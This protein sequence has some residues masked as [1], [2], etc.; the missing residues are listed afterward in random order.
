ML[1]QTGGHGDEWMP[2]GEHVRW[3]GPPYPGSPDTI[4]DGPEAMRRKVR[5][6]IRDGADVI[7]VATSGG[8]LS[9]R[10]DPRNAHFRLDELEALATEAGAAGRWVMAH[11]QGADGIK[12]ADRAGIRSIDYSVYLDDEAMSII[13]HQVTYMVRTP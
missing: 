8:V 13:R 12:N 2:F 11:A 7:K 3:L 4:V 5:E 10:D 1:S 6:L 9:P